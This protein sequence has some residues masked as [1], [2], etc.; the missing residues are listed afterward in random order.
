MIVKHSVENYESWKKQFDAN[1]DA[2]KKYGWLSHS[3]SR[4]P[5]EPNTVVVISKVKSLDQVKAFSQDPVVRERMATS[6][7]KEHSL[8]LMLEE[9][10]ET[11]Y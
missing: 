5:A 1:A 4:D 3:I 8:R 7:V 10:E 9:A 2:R 6:G 11:R